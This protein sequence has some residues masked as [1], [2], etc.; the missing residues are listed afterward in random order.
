MT[1]KKKPNIEILKYL[2]KEFADVSRGDNLNFIKELEVTALMDLFYIYRIQIFEEKQGN[3]VLDRIDK[4][5]VI[6]DRISQKIEENAEL[7]GFDF[8]KENESYSN[9]MLRI[10]FAELLLYRLNNVELEEKTETNVNEQM[11]KHIQ[12]ARDEFSNSSTYVEQDSLAQAESLCQFLHCSW[13]LFTLT[14]N[15]SYMEGLSGSIRSLGNFI[16]NNRGALVRIHFLSISVDIIKHFFKMAKDPAMVSQVDIGRQRVI[17]EILNA[18]FFVF[19]E[20]IQFCE[21]DENRDLTLDIVFLNAILEDLE[22]IWHHSVRDFDLWFNGFYS[23]QRYAHQALKKA[24]YCRDYNLIIKASEVAKNPMINTLYRLPILEQLVDIYANDNHQI[25]SLLNN[26]KQDR[27]K[28]FSTSKFGQG[29]LFEVMDS[30][31]KNYQNLLMSITPLLPRNACSLFSQE[32][33]PTTEILEENQ[34]NLKLIINYDSY[35]KLF[36]VQ[37]WWKGQVFVYTLGEDRER[38]IIKALDNYQEAVRQSTVSTYLGE[39]FTWQV[40]IDPNKIEGHLELVNQYRKELDVIFWKPLLK[41]IT[42]TISSLPD[43]I[44]IYPDGPAWHFPFAGF[45]WNDGTYLGQLFPIIHLPSLSTKQ[46]MNMLRKDKRS[47]GNHISIVRG[48]T[49]HIDEKISLS[50]AQ[51]IQSVGG[52]YSK[53]FS[54]DSLCTIDEFKKAIDTDYLHIISHSELDSENPLGGAFQLGDGDIS[55]LNLFQS[56]TGKGPDLVSFSSCWS[57]QYTDVDEFG[58]G[59]M[60]R[61]L[62]AQGVPSILAPTRE[63]FQD[64]TEL[65]ITKFYEEIMNGKETPSKALLKA[66]QGLK[67]TLWENPFF[68]EQFVLY[69]SE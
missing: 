53:I 7:E 41:I 15:I 56:I 35:E 34:D 45:T 17:A 58:L 28:L 5:M 24:L 25:L 51:K 61:S 22:T 67:G 50:E 11:V 59:P 31:K 27:A 64:V 18:Y 52:E 30:V 69:S 26:T 48:K 42:E 32:A 44:E 38:Q 33:Y 37:M 46:Q 14:K 49:N 54:P 16:K 13:N 8:F 60:I 21:N 40:Y 20:M 68:W 6:F 23:A 55:A 65:T 63:V 57:G 1:T 36:L 12:K 4:A 10:F 2:G 29:N 62:V 9:G 47:I 19:P 39:C 3:K 43:M 66:R